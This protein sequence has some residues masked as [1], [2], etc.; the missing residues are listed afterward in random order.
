MEMFRNSGSIAVFDSKFEKTETMEKGR[1]DW[2]MAF[3]MSQSGNPICHPEPF[4]SKSSQFW[5]FFKN[6][7]DRG[8]YLQ[9]HS[10]HCTYCK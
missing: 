3:V 9:V 1:D 8:D 4:R 6:K 2:N 7:A 5:K 10:D